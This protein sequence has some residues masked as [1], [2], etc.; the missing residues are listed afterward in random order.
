MSLLVAAIVLGFQGRPDAGLLA[1]QHDILSGDSKIQVGGGIPAKVV[2]FGDRAVVLAAAKDGKSTSSAIVAA[3]FEKGRV[4][5]IGHGAMLQSNGK[6]DAIGE[7]LGWL[8]GSRRK[9]GVFGQAPNGLKNSG[10]EFL[11][12]NA[13]RLESDLKQCGA[14]IAG[15]RDF[16]SVGNRQ[17]L[18][19]F[20]SGGGG[21]L[22]VDTTWGWL[23]LNPGK[24]VSVDH[25]A[26]SFLAEMGIGF[27][28]G[29]LDSEAGTLQLVKPQP[30]H[31]AAEALRIFESSEKV[32]PATS[33]IVSDVLTSV[34]RD[35]RSDAAF[36]NR[37]LKA[38]E[39]GAAANYP[40]EGRP[41]NID[42]FRTRLGMV[43]YDLKWRSLPARKI[44]AH[45]AAKD[46]PGAVGQFEPR[47][48]AV[49]SFPAQKRRWISTG[50][51]AAPGELVTV[52][53]GAGWAGKNIRLRI[54]GH[55]DNNWG[56]EKWERW[57]SITLE[58]P[59]V[60]GKAEAANPFGGMVYLVCPDEL[61]SGSAVFDGTVAAPVY[62]L[63]ST[64]DAD[65]KMIRRSGAP[66]GEIVGQ[67]SAICVPS[68]VLKEL[69]DPKAVAEYF[70]EMVRE[71]EKFYAVDPGTTEHR[72]QADRQ[73]VAGYMHAGYPIMTWLDVTK[74]FVDIKVLRGN[75]GGPLWGFYHELGHNYQKPNWTW[76]GWGETTNNLFSEYGEEHFNN[77][78][79]G[80]GAMAADEMAKRLAAVKGS[81]GSEAFYNK[82]PWYGLTFWTMI[83]REFGFEK[84][85]EYFAWCK[86]QN[87]TSE[88]AKK[89]T[90]VVEMSRIVGRDL[91]RYCRMWGVDVSEE[92]AAK[93][94][95]YPQ[96][97]PKDLE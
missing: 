97:L 69:D 75:D 5:A 18:K 94:G 24:S 14:L 80:H 88:K 83:R 30:A 7:L 49:V 48:R 29:M 66:W 93:A 51:Y 37:V 82:D 10:F 90:F 96:W 68:E 19:G 76:N 41:V 15:P 8:C 63:G 52:Q 1:L 20:V 45:A 70:D 6:G 79:V 84:L 85:T 44:T 31:H 27:A 4:A 62:F 46:F 65:W 50:R 43:A 72:Y 36:T 67:Q 26:Q 53:L 9:V 40:V 57:P 87:M 78:V 92:A 71:A 89:D 77:Q 16:E 28:G 33:G 64:S 11:S 47:E 55:A 34:L 61:P 56:L 86:D 22:V 35:G 3:D 59:I 12:L 38:V 25:P 32:D 2:A 95:K 21:L 74:R 60:N 58:E 23:Q 91:T 39:S 54:G 13:S 73:I 81:P 17:A 42:D